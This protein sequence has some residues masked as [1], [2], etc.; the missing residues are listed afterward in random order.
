MGAYLCDLMRLTCQGLDKIWFCRNFVTTH[1]REVKVHLQ[2]LKILVRVGPVLF[3]VKN[4]CCFVL[5]VYLQLSTMSIICVH[6]V[7]SCFPNERS[8]LLSFFLMKYSH[9]ILNIWLIFARKSKFVASHNNFVSI[10]IE[11]Q[12]IFESF[13]LI[14]VQ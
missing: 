6:L 14:N 12:N 10:K 2:Q 4:T 11:S 3:Q 5:I 13:L 7:R 1:I 8:F 9:V